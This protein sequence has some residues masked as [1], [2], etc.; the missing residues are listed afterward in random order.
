MNE[1]TKR[2]IKD[3]CLDCV[4]RT[5]ERVTK[6]LEKER[7]GE[8]FSNPFQARLLNDELI[9]PA[10]FVRSFVT[11]FGMKPL[12]KISLY[13]ALD[14]VDTTDGCTQKETFVTISQNTL[15]SINRLVEQ[16]KTNVLGRKALWSEDINS[17][18]TSDENVITHKVISDLW[19]KR[20]G[21]DHFVSIKTVQPNK[22][23]TEI[24]KKD[25]LILKFGVE[26]SRPYF[27]LPYNP[28]GHYKED[29][30]HSP[31]YTF[32]NMI[33]DEVVLI[34][35]EYWDFLGGE[36]TYETLLGVVEEAG[37]ETRDMVLN[38]DLNSI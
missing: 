17:I 21:V 20:N 6:A 1:E 35:K 32:F 12:E 19:F 15:D 10:K 24:A 18:V 36:G 16:Q 34:G 8:N 29:Y 28:Y 23:Q 38:M 7:E 14:N 4:R 37:R 3:E 31:P 11:S 2:K 5:I 26:G 13:I 33:E 22:D 30:N 25:S 9:I 27:A